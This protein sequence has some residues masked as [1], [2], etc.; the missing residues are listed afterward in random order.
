MLLQVSI[1]SGS[2]CYGTSNIA[3]EDAVRWCKGVHLADAVRQGSQHK[4]VGA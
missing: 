1:L 4:N 3:E 2:G